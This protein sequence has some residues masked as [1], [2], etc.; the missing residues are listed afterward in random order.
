MR[1]RLSR[2]DVEAF[3]AAVDGHAPS[4]RDAGANERVRAFVDVVDRVRETPVPTARPDFVADLRSQLMVAA[5]DEL[6]RP[7]EAAQQE[8][9]GPRHRIPSQVRVRRRLTAAATAFVVAGGSFGLVA[10]SA[11]SMPGDMLYPVKRATERAELILRDGAGEGRTLLD[12]AATRLAEVEALANGSNPDADDLIARTLDD[13][14]DDANAG[15]DLLIDAYGES[16]SQTDID[17]VRRFTAESAQ[18]LENLADA[19][20]H[21]A[22]TEY[23]DAARAVSGLDSTAVGLC[24]TCGDGSPP[25]NVDGDLLDAVAY[26][27]DKSDP[28]TPTADA[29][30]LKHRSLNGD[31]LGRSGQDVPRDVDLPVLPDDLTSGPP[32]NDATSPSGGDDSSTDSRPSSDGGLVGELEDTT[33]DLTGGNSKP[34]DSKP[35]DTEGGVGGLLSPITDPVNE[36]LKDLNGL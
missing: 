19:M 1:S 29:S 8:S 28:T 32:S 21:A 27:L 2:R 17:D 4:G 16:G 7:D 22:A 13:F 9:T 3:A 24:P 35:N 33:D 25:V 20:P 18:R 31:D 15:G 10:A 26:V 5:V 30:D 36:L 34:D 14:T 11:Q 6:P 23:A 12:H